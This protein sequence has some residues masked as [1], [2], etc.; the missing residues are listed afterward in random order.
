MA[1]NSGGITLTQVNYF[2]RLMIKYGVFFIIGFLLLRAGYYYVLDSFKSFLPTAEV[3]PTAGFGV[4][5]NPQF[6]VKKAFEKP[7]S[8][9]LALPVVRGKTKFPQFGEHNL[10]EVYPYV[11]KSLSLTTEEKIK[12]L[13]SMYGFTGEPKI[14]N[15]TTYR[16]EK[17]KKGLKFDLKINALSNH[18]T[19]VS[20]YFRKDDFVSGSD[21]PDKFSAMQAVQN[22]LQVGNLLPAKFDSESFQI[23]YVK[24]LST[25]LKEVQNIHEA[26]FLK[27]DLKRP[28]IND[29]Y[30][31][32]YPDPRRLSIEVIV[33]AY[34]NRKMEIVAMEYQYSDLDIENFHT[35]PLRSVE[36]AWLILQSGEGYIAEKA[37][38]PEA[39]V[40]KI[41]LA[42][43]ETYENQDYLQ[44]VYVF[45]NRN[46]FL[47]YVPAIDPH[48]LEPKQ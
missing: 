22:Y 4:L 13:V 43:Y 28:K 12:K 3:R 21:L 48:Y 29:E 14:L 32:V 25:N 9:A 27:V 11:K 8:Y 37:N 6:K 31:F 5:P 44:P 16:F 1:E 15:E 46:G 42:Y 47:A 33:G 26:N 23:S 19:L 36:S 38:A 35:Y 10:I 34:E 20:D 40:E 17:E 39:I 2:F 7:N 45:S 41:D 24:A 30:G 18:M